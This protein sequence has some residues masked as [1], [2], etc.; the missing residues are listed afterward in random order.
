ML[1]A[2]AFCSIHVL[3]Q[4]MTTSYGL[5]GSRA[6]FKSPRSVFRSPRLF[7][8]VTGWAEKVGHR[9]LPH[10]WFF[11]K[12]RPTN[13]I[14][15]PPLWQTPG[16]PKRSSRS[17]RI[18]RGRTANPS[19]IVMACCPQRST[20]ATDTPGV[21]MKPTGL[22]ENLVPLRVRGSQFGEELDV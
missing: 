8:T 22:S 4:S 9:K 7:I 1:C 15:K 17:A 13:L 18:Y 19:M 5:Y 12:S 16:K 14:L 20:T 11:P 6:S 2:G 10:L 21:D 3:G